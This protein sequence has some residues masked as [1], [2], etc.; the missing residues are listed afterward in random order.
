MYDVLLGILQSRYE[1]TE[2]DI[3]DFQKKSDEYSELWS[4]IA[5]LDGQTN[6]EH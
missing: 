1:F 4:K 3:V 5:G 2:K 6:Y